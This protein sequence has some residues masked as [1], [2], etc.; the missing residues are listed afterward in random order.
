MSEKIYIIYIIYNIIYAASGIHCP[1][2]YPRSKGSDDRAYHGD[3]RAVIHP[4]PPQTLPRNVN[5]DDPVVR[6]SH[7]DVHEIV[8]DEQVHHLGASVH[9]INGHVIEKRVH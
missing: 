6:V 5:V 7:K 1:H 3:G 8:A 4:H 2:R 9:E